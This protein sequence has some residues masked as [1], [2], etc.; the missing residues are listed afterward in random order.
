MHEDSKTDTRVPSG[1]N[2]AASVLWALAFAAA[3]SAGAC[4]GDEGGDDCQ[5]GTELC[6]C[7]S[8]Q[9]FSGLTCDP[10]ANVCVAG[11]GTGGNQT[12]REAELCERLDECNFL[13]PGVSAADCADE[14]RL[15][16]GDLIS[17]AYADWNNEAAE[18]LELNN[19]KNFFECQA[20]L[21]DCV[22]AGGGG[23][24]GGSCVEDGMP[25]EYCNNGAQC[26]A[27]YFGD[28]WCDCDCANGYDFD[29]G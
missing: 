2:L 7:I 26:P 14:L 5:P 4:S 17:S 18:C 10:M 20:T 24:G 13:E 21:P 8:G 9:C 11:Q 29:C 3:V 12:D 28:G 6:A 16:T 23:G 25:C 19:C 27:S 15:C 22:P 1:R